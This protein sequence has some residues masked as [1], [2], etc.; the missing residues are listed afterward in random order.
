MELFSNDQL[1]PSLEKWLSTDEAKDALVTAIAQARQV[2]AQ[3]Q[4]A[5][6]VSREELALPVT[7]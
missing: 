6:E 3:L 4:K 1:A 2:G 5:R 7:V